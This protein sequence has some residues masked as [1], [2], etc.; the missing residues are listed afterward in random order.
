LRLGAGA[1]IR[2][3]FNRIVLPATL[4]PQAQVRF[5]RDLHGFVHRVWILTP[6]E[7]AQPDPLK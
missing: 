1:Q 4:P 5:T 2:D 6:A 3:T 7:A